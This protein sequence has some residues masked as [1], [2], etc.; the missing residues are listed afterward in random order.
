MLC[1]KE[2]QVG[3]SH[4]SCALDFKNLWKVLNPAEKIRGCRS[5]VFLFLHVL[6]EREFEKYVEIEILIHCY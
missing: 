3:T 6:F 1:A 5:P 4:V 2:K